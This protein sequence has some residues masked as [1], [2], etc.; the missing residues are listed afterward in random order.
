MLAAFLGAGPV[1]DAFFVAFRLP[2]HFRAI[3]AEGAFN[4]AFIPAYAR[5]RTQEGKDAAEIF[6][7]RIFTLLLATQIVLLVLALALHAAGHRSVGARLLARAAAISV[8][9]FAHPHHLS[10]SPAHYAGD[11]L[12]RHSQRAASLRRRRSG[13]DPAQSRDD[14]NARVLQAVRRRRLCGGVGRAH[15]RRAAGAAGRRRHLARGRLYRLSRAAARSRRAPLLRG[16]GA[17]DRRLGGHAARAVRRYHHRQL[18]RHRRDLGALLRR[19]HRSIADRRDRHRR[20]HRAAAGNDAADRCRRSCR[21]A[22][23]AEPRHRIRAAPRHPVHRRAFWWCPTPSCAACSCA[24]VSPPT[25][26]TPPRSR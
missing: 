25:M 22:L 10:V 13:A 16:F 15:I 7:D 18:S 2:N 21:R 8:G 3:F 6:G 19:P 5:I 1:A 12:G 4:A 26:R 14:R 20:R 24:A 17:G 23:G 11:A 9:D